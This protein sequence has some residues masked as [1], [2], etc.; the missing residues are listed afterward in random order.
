MSD[1]KQFDEEL[2]QAILTG[3]ALEAFEKFYADDVVMVEG[4]GETFEG[5]DVNRRREEEFFGSVEEF[6]GASIGAKG[7]GDNVSLAEWVFDVTFK[8]GS[9][10]KMEQAVVRTWKDGKVVRERFYYHGAH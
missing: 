2:D 3:K 8:G 7:F 1:W 9:R 10:V 4:T 6:H 5:K